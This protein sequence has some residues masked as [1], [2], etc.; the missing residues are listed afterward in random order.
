MSGAAHPVTLTDEQCDALLKKHTWWNGS[1][2][3]TDHRQMIREAITSAP[4]QPAM[5]SEPQIDI[6]AIAWAYKKLLAYGIDNSSMSNALMLDRLNLM[7][8][9]AQ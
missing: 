5:P 7:L 1:H 6:E 3:M 4:P 9:E 8:L 2:A